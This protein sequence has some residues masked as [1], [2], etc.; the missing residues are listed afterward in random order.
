MSTGRG[1][2]VRQPA[3]RCETRRFI[4]LKALDDPC[5]PA[6]GPAGLSGGHAWGVV[7]VRSHCLRH[8]FELEDPDGDPRAVQRAGDYAVPNLT[9][10]KPGHRVV[11]AHPFRR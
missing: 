6:L 8:W 4:R 10:L 3:M 1:S 2:P 11:G 7:P 9:W 5:S